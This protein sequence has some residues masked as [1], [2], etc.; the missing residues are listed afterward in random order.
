[1]RRLLDRTQP[2]RRSAPDYTSRAHGRVPI[3]SSPPPC[4]LS[5][6]L[7]LAGGVSLRGEPR[8]GVVA[9][10]QNIGLGACALGGA[11]RVWRPVVALA[12]S[13]PPCSPRV[14]DGCGTP[15][16]RRDAR[17]GRPGTDT[18]NPATRRVRR[19]L[20]RRRTHPRRRDERQ[21]GRRAAPSSPR[22]SKS[23]REPLGTLRSGNV[24]SAHHMRFVARR[25]STARGGA[26]CP[27]AAADSRLAGSWWC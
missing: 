21:L 15:S 3:A 9:R 16:R 17:C 14:S 5:S 23:R 1:M 8:G 19:R 18:T 4:S 25:R 11:R 26:D 2:I 12:H 24:D 10:R 20:S 7:T 27:R 22:R 13:R 6:R